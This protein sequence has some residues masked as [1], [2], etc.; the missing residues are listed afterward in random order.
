M[1]ESRFNYMGKLMF[2]PVYQHF[3]HSV[4]ISS[5]LRVLRRWLVKVVQLTQE[6]T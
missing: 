4:V 2:Q 6:R 3:S 5:T 1:N